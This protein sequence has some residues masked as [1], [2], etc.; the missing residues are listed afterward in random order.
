MKEADNL[1]NNIEQSKESTSPATVV[2]PEDMT[3]VNDA[4]NQ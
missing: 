1:D 3:D 4:A 2:S